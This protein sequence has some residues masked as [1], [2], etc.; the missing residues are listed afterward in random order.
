MA[1]KRT[2]D[3]RSPDAHNDQTMLRAKLFGRLAVGVDGS[4]VPPIAGLKPRS[5]LV[6]LLLHPG[7]HPRARLA[8][9]FWP[10][11]L[12][13]SA[14]ASLRSAL[15][16][17]RGAL[18][19]AG[20]EAYL[21]GDRSSVGI[22]PDLPREVD[23]E[24]FDRALAVGDAA[25]CERRSR[26][27]PVPC[28]P[29]SRTNGCWIARRSATGSSSRSNALPTAPSRRRRGR[30]DRVDQRALEQDRLREGSY[31]QLIRRLAA[32]P[33][34]RLGAHRL[35]RRCRAVLAAELGI[36]RRPG[37]G[38]SSR[39]YGRG[40][41]TRPTAWSRDRS[42]PSARRASSAAGPSS[43]RSPTYGGPARPGGAASR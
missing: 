15:W 1:R 21:A 13:T 14:R 18:E 25:F 19:A 42:R 23:V 6:Y 36:A 17:V 30:R 32:A 40:A 4:S 10:D 28:C 20:G 16:S 39:G 35:H 12:D 5:V 34:S 24:Q 29:T 22:S 9:R 2:V 33:G 43:R 38:T 11:V 7:L 41:P 8:T 37:P 31:R 26:S 27:P 3:A